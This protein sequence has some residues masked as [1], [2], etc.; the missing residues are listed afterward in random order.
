MSSIAQFGS[1][2]LQDFLP[3]PSAKSEAPPPA[4]IDTDETPAP[5]EPEQKKRPVPTL[6]VPPT[7]ISLKDFPELN[8][9][10]ETV[11]GEEDEQPAEAETAVEET[12]QSPADKFKPTDQPGDPA[13]WAAFEYVKNNELMFIPEDFKFDGSEQMLNELY[14]YDQE[15]RGKLAEDSFYSQFKDPKLT[16]LFKYAQKA[17]GFAD[18]PAYLHHQKKED[19][20]QKMDPANEDQAKELIKHFY[21]LKQV[22]SFTVE[23]TI[24]TAI[25][26]DKLN[27]LA[28]QAKDEILA[29]YDDKLENLASTGIENNERNVQLQRQYQAAVN[30]AIYTSSHP[31]E[32]KQA[33]DQLIRPVQTQQGTYSGYEVALWKIQENPEAF[34][35]LLHFLATFDSNKPA[36]KQVKTFAERNKGIRLPSGGGA[37]SQTTL[38]SVIV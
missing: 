32:I 16:E 21:E 6:Q 33:M 14:E 23:A 30:K 29:Y 9:P 36:A 17:G 12:P 15:Q 35:K 19:Y 2:K 7:N 10:Q 28:K 18:I 5:T 22:P 37:T 1:L 20:F 11:L 34:T 4:I 27:E 26:K 8:P 24:E 31:K 3:K 38:E 25:L 13:L